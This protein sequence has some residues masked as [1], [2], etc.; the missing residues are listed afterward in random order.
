MTDR[1]AMTLILNGRDMTALEQLAAEKGV[2]KT[3]VIKQ[4]IRLYQSMSE[5]IVQGDKLY[6][7]NPISKDKAELMVL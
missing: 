4:A 3:A 2:S 1:K 6:M 7:E 5:R